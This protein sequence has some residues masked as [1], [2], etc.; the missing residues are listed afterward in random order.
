[1]T[2]RDQL[3]NWNFHWETSWIP[4]IVW[5]IVWICISGK[6]IWDYLKFTRKLLKNKNL[7]FSDKLVNLNCSMSVPFD[8][9]YV[10]GKRPKSLCHNNFQ[11][12]SA[13]AKKVLLWFAMTCAKRMFK[14]GF[15]SFHEKCVVNCYWLIKMRIRGK[16]NSSNII[17]TRA[18]ALQDFPSK[19]CRID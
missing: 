18:V 10:S 4:G 19:A 14:S 8:W 15:K 9:F 12:F 11:R 5:N 2:W 1:M 13:T 6:Y 7:S 17:T 3:Q 16:L